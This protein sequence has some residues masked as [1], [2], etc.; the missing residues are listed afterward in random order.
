ML[1]NNFPE[2]GQIIVWEGLSFDLELVA[3]HVIK[4]VRIKDVDGEKHIFSKSKHAE[5]VEQNDIEASQTVHE[6]E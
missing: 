3:D 5:L 6:K 1:G 4:Q 2:Q